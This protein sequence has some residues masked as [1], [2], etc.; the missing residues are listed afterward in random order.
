M[1]RLSALLACFV[2]ALGTLSGWQ[3]AVAPAAL[4]CSCAVVTDDDLVEQSAII[5]DVE[6][7]GQG[8]STEPQQTRYALKVHRVWKGEHAAVISMQTNTEGAACGLGRLKPGTRSV[9]WGLEPTQ[10]A[11]GANWCFQPKVDT[12]V[13][14]LLAERFGDPWTPTEPVTTAPPERGPAS[15]DAAAGV[16]A[17]LGLGAL[18][19]AWFTTRPRRDR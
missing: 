11:Y 10:G 12:D 7:L 18:G 16:V 19:Y 3:V 6:V 4:A 13:E 14:A 2:V 5:A 1:R 9:L 15:L 8:T 17:A